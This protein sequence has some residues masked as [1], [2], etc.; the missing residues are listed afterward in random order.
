MLS[1]I[2][3]PPPSPR[4][5]LHL[6]SGVP[7]DIYA[8]DNKFLKWYASYWIGGNTRTD[9][10]SSGDGDA[11]DLFLSSFASSRFGL[12]V[13]RDGVPVF[14]VP[15]DEAE[16]LFSVPWTQMAFLRRV[17]NGLDWVAIA[18]DDARISRDIGTPVT[19]RLWLPAARGIFD[20]WLVAEKKPEII[21]VVK[22]IK[23]GP[24]R[25]IAGEKVGMLPLSFHGRWGGP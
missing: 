14:G 20:G 22:S 11:T 18:S 5:V 15:Q 21:G 3:F 24:A 17:K 19:L 7:H 10:A 1:P 13:T 16:A 25:Q 12:G 2:A 9:L 8:I 4:D 23:T 6:S